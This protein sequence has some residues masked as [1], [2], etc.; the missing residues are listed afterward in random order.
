MERQWV[1]HRASDGV[2]DGVR[3]LRPETL[4]MMMANCLS[5]DQRGRGEVAGLPVF[6]SGHGFGLGIA[7]VTEPEATIPVCVGAAGA[8][9]WPDGLRWWRAD[10]NDGSPRVDWSTDG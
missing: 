9:G 7:V 3:I 6:A 1:H 2:V 4:A 8:V 5:D 10:P